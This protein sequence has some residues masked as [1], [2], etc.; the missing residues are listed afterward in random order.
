MRRHPASSA[1]F[2]SVSDLK[3]DR[4]QGQSSYAALLDDEAQVPFPQVSR[5]G[6]VAGSALPPFPEGIL[7]VET[8]GKTVICFG[9]YKNQN[10]TYMDLVMATDNKAL[11]YVK[12][13]KSH[14]KSAQGH[15]KDLCNFMMH[16]SVDE[17]TSF[18]LVIPGTTQTRVLRE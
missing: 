11:G 9:Q 14:S 7:D 1:K 6:D 3:G 10:M 5:P 13:C 16:H 2:K 8:W 18:G 17:G 15:L 4:N 12:W